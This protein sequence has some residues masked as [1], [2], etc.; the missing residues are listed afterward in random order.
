[1][2]KK[3]ALYKLIK[4]LTKS[5]KRYFKISS[6][7]ESKNYLALF[8]FIDKQK[9]YDEEA[10]KKHFVGKTF[11]K[12]LHVT[13]NYLSKLILKSLKNFHQKSSKDIEIKNL[14]QDIEILY[15]KDLYDICEN[16]IEKCIKLAEEYEKFPSLLDAL[17]WKRKLLITRFGATE[18]RK[19]IDSIIEKQND[20][21]K[22]LF[23]LN[24][25]YELTANFFE[26]FQTASQLT[27]TVY[28]S[29][30]KNPLIT[31]PDNALTFQSKVLYC[32]LLFSYQIY[33]DRNYQAAFQS[34]EHLVALLERNPEFLREDP[35]NYITAINHQIEILLH[36]KKYTEVSEL[37]EKIRKAPKKFNFKEQ[38][39]GLIKPILQTYIH[40]ID[41]FKNTNQIDKAIA[42][43]P[44]IEDLL[45]KYKTKTL[46]D[47]RIIFFLY[48][49]YLHLLKKEHQKTRYYLEKI[50]KYPDT[51]NN[52]ELH[53]LAHFLK[54]MNE[55][56]MEHFQALNKLAGATKNFIKQYHRPRP[57]Q[58]LLI[59]FFQ[60]SAKNYSTENL[61]SLKTQLEILNKDQDF[62]KAL[63]KIDFINWINDQ[64]YE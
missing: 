28:T 34:L 59:T 32:N 41:L 62:D 11:I 19:D 55:Y 36:T 56:E 37:F 26:Y 63:E 52:F 14:L 33:K 48:F 42:K 38:K 7:E 22:K 61:I 12:Q 31:N 25:Y 39:R 44:E 35:E 60:K 27:P 20:T 24:E 8:D 29:L 23:N 10:V 58:K 43:I 53:S 2:V 51:N 50:E 1:M 30:S 17:N 4:S 47:L 40:E 54:L 45:K 46:D 57:F 3:G 21:L 13:K 16:E 64:I 15:K 18:S 5:E 6:A 49:A 9:K